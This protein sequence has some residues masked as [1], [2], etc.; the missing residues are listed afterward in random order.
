MS[1]V[2][3][4]NEFRLDRSRVSA[5]TLHRWF[6][7]IREKGGLVYYPY[8]RANALGL[9][10]VL[11]T[12]HG[13]HDPR[14]LSIV[15][16]AASFNVETS[17]DRGEP[18]VRQGYWVP[19]NAMAEFREFWR[20]AHDLGLIGEFEIY[21][22]RN[23]HFIFS[24]FEDVT[25]EQGSAVWSHPSD[26]SYFK[27]LIERDFREPFEVRLGRL[28]IDAPLM[29]PLVVEHIWEHYSSRQ[30][31]QAIGQRDLSQAWKYAK[32]LR[33]RD[34]RKPGAAL[35]LLQDQWEHLMQN[36]EEVFIQPRV[37]FNWPILKNS[38]FLSAMMRAPSSKA[39]VEA[40]VRMSE[41]SIVTGLKPSVE[42]DGA[43]HVSCFL[44]SDQ[45]AHVARIIGGCHSSN[46]PPIIAVQDRAATLEL[47]QPSFCK[48]DWNYFD[49]SSL[50]WTF[51]GQ[52]YQ[53]RVKRL[54]PAAISPPAIQQSA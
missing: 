19:A 13:L 39:M 38:T 3:I 17:L 43:C 5:R 23:T 21:P 42:L 27:S 4:S 53:E 36:F 28:M 51:D 7:V 54:K 11:L 16:F 34:P 40:V 46:T 20:T 24:R 30:V 50:S 2:E 32:G 26:N 9:A 15:P 18:L 29:I 52:K 45:L 31:W 33:P 10:D 37:F 12:I 8:P 48:L 35:H 41:R 47:F 49:P 22:S 14:V 25:T 44:P 1:P 6:S